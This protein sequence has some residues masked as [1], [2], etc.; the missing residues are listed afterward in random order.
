L[1]EGRIGIAAQML[2]LAEGAYEEALPY[3][4]QRKQFGSAIGNFQVSVCV[5]FFD[6]FSMS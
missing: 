5:Y 3:L 1:N 6:Y 4:F 2:G